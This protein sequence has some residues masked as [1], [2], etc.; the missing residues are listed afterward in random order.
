MVESWIWVTR[1]LGLKLDWVA[2][3]FW[4]TNNSSPQSDSN[5][6]IVGPYWNK[7]SAAVGAAK[8]FQISFVA[9]MVS[10]GWGK[11]L[12]VD[13]IQFSPDCA[14]VASISSPPMDVST[15]AGAKATFTCGVK[16][17]P[18]PTVVWLHNGDAL[19]TGNFTG[20]GGRIWM[21]VTNTLIFNSTVEKDSGVYTCNATNT[22]GS[23]TASATLVILSVSTGDWGC[24]LV[25]F[26]PMASLYL[27]SGSSIGSSTLLLPPPPEM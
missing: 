6:D 13:N 4:I 10:Y 3:V 5:K 15:P 2:A 26:R 16:G 1:S 24:N 12:A 11:H 9:N 7:T 22:M 19:G 25:L 20:D 18:I 27:S 23:K 21:D 14:V 8:D 17:D